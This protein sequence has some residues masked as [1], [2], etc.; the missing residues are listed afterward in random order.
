MSRSLEPPPSGEIQGE[1]EAKKKRERTG[2][3]GG[4]RI[5]ADWSLF[6]PPLFFLRDRLLLGRFLSHAVQARPIMNL[7]SFFY[8]CA[9]LVSPPPELL[10]FS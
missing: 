10:V 1:R 5:Q 9:F 4:D 2:K 8:F 3:R 6:T 7:N